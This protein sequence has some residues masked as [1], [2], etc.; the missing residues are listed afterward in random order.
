MAI[1]SDNETRQT[2][3]AVV[4]VRVP[5]GADG[6]LATEAERRLSRADGVLDVT[7]EGIRGL[8]PGLS[9][10]VVTVVVTVET[11]GGVGGPAAAAVLADE[12]GLEVHDARSS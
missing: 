11:A 12:V 2:N 3:E 9:A 8:E 7:V 10:T 4:E 5:S 6:D 1:T